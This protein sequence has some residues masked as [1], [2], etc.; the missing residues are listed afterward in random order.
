MMKIK[1]GKPHADDTGLCSLLAGANQSTTLSISD[2]LILKKLLE[3]K[4]DHKLLHLEG[5]FSATDGD[6]KGEIINTA[7]KVALVMHDSNYQLTNLGLYTLNSNEHIEIA[8]P[9]QPSAFIIGNLS[10]DSEWYAVDR[11]ADAVELYNHMA[12]NQG[13]NITILVSLNPYG[14]NSM[15]KH[16][17]EVKQVIVTTTLDKQD[18]LI[19]PLLGAK[20]K[21]IITVF[22]LLLSFDNG[23]SLDDVINDTETIVKDLQLEAWDEPK[24]ITQTLPPVKTISSD[25][26]PSILWRYTDNQAH[27][28]STPHEYVGVPLI[29]SIA[30]VLGTKVSIF[31][32]MLDY[33]EVVPNLWG[34]IIG[35]PSTKKSPALDA[36]V[37]PLHNLRYKAQEEYEYIKRDFAT[38]KEVNELK[39]KAAREEL[40][41]LAKE[42]LKQTDDADN[43]ITDDALKS[44]AQ[45]IADASVANETI[46]ILKRYIAND[47]THQMLGELLKQTHNGILVERDELTGL[48]ASLEGEQN[49]EARSFYLQGFNGTGSHVVD[50]IGRG[51]IFIENH[52]LSLIGGIQPDKLQRYLEST[53]KGLGNDGLMQRFQLSVYPDHIKG[54]KEKDTAVDKELLQ[55]VYD[56]FETIDNMTISDFIEYGACEPDDFCR[57]PHFRFTKEAA[58]YFLQWYDRIIAKADA[59]EYAIIAEHLIKYTKTVP[60]LALIFHLIDCIEFGNNLGGVSLTALQTAIKW[61]EMLETHMYRI[62]SIVTDRANNKASYLGEKILNMVRLASA[63]SDESANNDWLEHGFTARDLK[64]RNWKGL[65]RHDKDDVDDA[66]DILVEHNWLICELDAGMGRP[67]ERYFI[68]PR[69]TKFL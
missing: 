50:R 69:L 9:S 8:D 53:T 29:I 58:Q 11:L 49:A 2:D 57:R 61:Q 59:S 41:K 37:K 68:N 64:R 27:R 7:G 38:Q 52:C 1:K 60:S 39:M 19:K 4:Q 21:A 6:K 14:F 16:F 18:Q 33:W 48:L 20:V 56:L 42:Q 36:G 67:T 55:A 30:S 13:L 54:R 40:K 35:N 10:L 62:Y 51:S 47:S 25:M 3:F 23:L 31:P 43:P 46:P 22:E 32:K 26:M 15:V 63:K 5:G 44:K 34:A 65:T 66:L 28:L 17:A 24:P 12:I 45:I